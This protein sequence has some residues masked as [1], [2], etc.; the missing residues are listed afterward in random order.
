MITMAVL[1][2][3]LLGAVSMPLYWRV[4]QAGPGGSLRALFGDVELRMLLAGCLRAGGLLT[5][6][7]WE[8]GTARYW[9][10]GLL[11]GISALTTTGFATLPVADMGTATKLLMSIAMLVG[12]SVGS[13]AGGF[14]LLCLLILCM[15]Q[16]T[17]RRLAMPPYAVAVPYRSGHKLD[18]DDILRSLMISQ[19]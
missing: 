3:A 13:T 14:K 12:G 18:N 4:V 11:M 16:L 1:A 10:H 6:F 2:D 5:W 7:A 8:H 17:L 19:R 9:F 15:L